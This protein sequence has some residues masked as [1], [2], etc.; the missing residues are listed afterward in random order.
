MVDYIEIGQNIV[1]L[2]N[3]NGITQEMLALE[4]DISVSFLRDVEHGR[5]NV[6]LGTLEKL[7]ATL[8]ITVWTIILYAT[9][10]E[11]IL[12]ALHEARQPAMEEAVV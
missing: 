4:S 6:S 11:I 5:V 8:G 2:R 3:K 12:S 9:D 10:D 1:A 7:A